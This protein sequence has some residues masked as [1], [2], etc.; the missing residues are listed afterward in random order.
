MRMAGIPPLAGAT[1]ACRWLGWL[2]CA[3]LKGVV[4]IEYLRLV[5]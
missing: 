1:S 2:R 5:R 3:Q 4:P